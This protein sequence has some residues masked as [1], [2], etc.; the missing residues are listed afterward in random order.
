MPGRRKDKHTEQ[1]ALL[2]APLSLYIS[3]SKVVNPLG[4]KFQTQRHGE[5]GLC[6][7]AL[8]TRML[9]RASSW[10]S[11]AAPC[12]VTEGGHVS[13]PHLQGCSLARVW[14]Q[15]PLPTACAP[16]HEAI[17]SPHTQS[18]ESLSFINQE[19]QSALTRSHPNAHPSLHA[20]RKSQ[21]QTYKGLHFL[22][23]TYVHMN[24]CIH[25]HTY[26]HTNKHKHTHKTNP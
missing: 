24:L 17:P 2:P 20:Q 5:G 25:I 8:P 4:L 9:R 6:S 15:L 7:P 19:G 13:H 3:G 18:R 14:S 12:G 10:A 21:V 1:V 16:Q 22:W 23:A 26:T 11:F